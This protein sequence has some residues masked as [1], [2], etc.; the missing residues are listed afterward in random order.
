MPFKG[1]QTGPQRSQWVA[2]VASRQSVVKTDIDRE[3]TGKSTRRTFR[4]GW[5]QRA[6]TDEPRNLG[7][8]T[9]RGRARQRGPVFEG[10]RLCVVMGGRTA[11]LINRSELHVV[12]QSSWP[13]NVRSSAPSSPMGTMECRLVNHP[14]DQ[15]DDSKENNRE[16]N[17]KRPE[18][19]RPRLSFSNVLYGVVQ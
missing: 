17:C 2:K 13:Y 3:A 4:G 14:R 11:D 9:G 6:E 10:P 1:S 16:N 18:N 5:R 19:P 15:S 8:L 7:Y 12:D